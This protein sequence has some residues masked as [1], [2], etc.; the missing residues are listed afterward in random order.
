MHSLSQSIY[1]INSNLES[2]RDFVDILD[3]HL[4]EK[5]Q[6][7]L[8]IHSS[9]LEFLLLVFEKLFE[10]GKYNLDSVP[11]ERMEEIRAKYP[12]FLSAES[13][14]NGNKID[15]TLKLPD[16]TNI[17]LDKIDIA[18][19]EIGKAQ[20][21]TRML[22]SSS[23]MTLTSSVELFFSKLF[24]QY[25]YLHPESIG[26]KEK[27]F[28]FDDLSKFDTLADARTHYISSRIEDLLRGPLSDWLLFARNTVKLSMGYLKEEQEL[29]EETF[30]RRN[31]VVHNGGIANSIYIAKVPK[32][33]CKDVKVS[34]NLRGCL[35]SR[36]N[37][38]KAHSV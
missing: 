23:L 18:L 4:S 34:N 1:E 26:T 17:E 32:N 29:L 20:G 11:P 30:Q 33:L 10:N 31:I 13:T 25:F 8:T 12:E 9:S 24:H 3:T 35:K 6:E 21:R 14:Q 2:L 38:R 37:S 22:Y 5:A 15:I 19:K 27:L 16:K 28:S 7:S 36:V